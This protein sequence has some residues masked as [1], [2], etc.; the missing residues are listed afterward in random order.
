MLGKTNTKE[1]YQLTKIGTLPKDWEI[2]KL[3]E[4]GD[5]KNGINKDKDQ[6]GYGHPLVGL[7][8]VFE[9]KTNHDKQFSLVNSSDKERELYCL[10]KGDVLFVRSS[11]KPTGVGL[12]SVIEKTIDNAVFSGFLI[13]FRDF[14]KL[15][16]NYKKQC[17]SETGFRQRLLAKSTISANT[18]I[19]QVALRS[20]RLAVP[21]SNEQYQIGKILTLWDDAINKCQTIIDYL[22]NRNKGLSQQLLFGKKRLQG[23]KSTWEDTPLGKCAKNINIRNKEIHGTEKLFAVTKKFGIIPMRE[24]VKGNTFN[25]CKIVRQNW[26]AYNP[27]RINIGSIALWEKPEEIMVSGDYVVFEC[28]E[29]KLLPHYLQYLRK[30]VIWESH[31]LIAGNGS[32]RIRI[33]FKD[34]AHFKFPLPPVKEQEAILEVLN[35]ANKELKLYQEKLA[36]LK[37]QKKGLMQ[38]LLTG[39]IRVKTNKT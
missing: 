32:V 6:F 18:N 38:K 26:F 25:N 34:L 15:D 13:R 14:G 37:E 2:K 7:N 31:M 20:L 21:P 3:G 17:F 29:N 30:T 33:Y 5:F 11:V 27:M 24:Q 4:L 10:S 28:D 8:D 39:E 9:L 22:S 19:N 35:N 16:L 1:G 12:I 23:F 36:V